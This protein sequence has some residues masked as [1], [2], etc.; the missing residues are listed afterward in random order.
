MKNKIT[1][2]YFFISTMITYSQ[3]VEQFNYQMRV[4]ENNFTQSNR[5]VTVKVSILETTIGGTPVYIE[6]HQAVSNSSGIINLHVGNGIPSSGNMSAINWSNDSFFI[7][8]EVDIDN[9]TSYDIT[10]TSQLLS[11]PFAMTAKQISEPTYS[12]GVYYPELGGLVIMVT[13]DGKHGIAAAG[14]QIEYGNWFAAHDFVRDPANYISTGGFYDVYPESINF[15]DW[16]LP[17]RSEGIYL[18]TYK[19]EL[20]MPGFVWT[21]SRRQED[22]DD[23]DGCHVLNT[24]TNTVN[25]TSLTNNNIAIAVRSF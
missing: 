1:I 19:T 10:S 4:S 14:G 11:V 2:I 17:N 3:S 13:P 23:I 24:Y 9:N 5:L 6:E 15:K 25:H 20:R 18:F 12:E 22:I 7:K 21:S 16:R 8:I